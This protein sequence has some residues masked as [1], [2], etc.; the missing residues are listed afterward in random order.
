MQRLPGDASI[1]D[2]LAW[3]LAT[4][5][6]PGFRDPETAL[7]LAASVC[8]RTA[9]RE[10]QALATLAAALASARRY[11]EAVEVAT[12]ALELARSGGRTKLGAEIALQ[13][14]AYRAGRAWIEPAPAV[15]VG[16]PTRPDVQ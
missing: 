12:R 4:C 10:P 1:A 13:S 7:Q 16:K 15:P 14:V 9:D 3:L 6:D 8:R 2:R 11:T 5:P